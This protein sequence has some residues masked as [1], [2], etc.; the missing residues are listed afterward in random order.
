MHGTG[1]TRGGY[2]YGQTSRRVV[3]RLRLSAIH[4]A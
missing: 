2:A 1:D 4:L 3:R